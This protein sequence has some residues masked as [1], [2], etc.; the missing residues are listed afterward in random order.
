MNLILDKSK[1][2]RIP[3]VFS[4]DTKQY[5]SRGENKDIFEYI[6][7]NYPE[8]YVEKKSLTNR[9]R[10]NKNIASFIKNLTQIGRSR[11]SL[12]YRDITVEYFDDIDD[13]K[14]YID[15]LENFK[16]WTF[17]PMTLAELQSSITELL[18]QVI[19]SPNILDV[20]EQDSETEYSIEIMCMERDIERQLASGYFDKDKLQNLILEC[21]MKKY[22]EDTSVQHITERLKAEFEKSS[23]LSAFSIELFDKTVSAVMINKNSSVSIMLKDGTIVGKE[24]CDAGTNN[25]AK[26]S[27]GDTT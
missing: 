3:I 21:A 25:N 10:T 22:N 5:L 9:I 24:N 18:N 8:I 19:I 1:N 26:T 2:L 16:G 14:S 27:S 7:I 12:D 20:P 17:I 13:I 15:Y 23:P 11:D 6:T 4:Y